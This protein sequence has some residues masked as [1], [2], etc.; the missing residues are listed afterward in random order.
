MPPF[1]TVTLVGGV[2]IAEVPSLGR[3]AFYL[4]QL[5]SSLNGFILGDFL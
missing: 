5:H 3:N 1:V 4:S 2:D